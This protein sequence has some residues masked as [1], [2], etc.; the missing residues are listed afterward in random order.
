MR[1]LI[2]DKLPPAGVTA[3]A[4]LGV[5]VDARPELGADDLPEV[6]RATG[7][8]I[9]V[10]RS[11]KVTADAFA[12]APGLGLV[13][14]AGAGVNTIDVAAANRHAV[15]VANCPGKN[16]IAVAELTMGLVL[17]LDRRLPEAVND[18]Q[19]G[20]W[21]KKRYGNARGLHGRRMGLVGFG[22]IGRE[23]AMRARA[24]GLVVEAYDPMLTAAAAADNEVELAADLDAMLGRCDV[25]SVHVPY[26]KKTHHLIGARELALL[27]DG[28]IVVHTARG[29]VV[30]D[31]ALADAVKAGRI[32]AALDV[33]EDEPAGSEAQFLSSVR[34]LPGIYATP[35]IGAS[36]D[37]AESA[38]AAE[39]VRIID[40]YLRT[41]H[42]G[43]AVNLDRD[44]VANFT[45]VVRHR[46]RVGVLATVLGLVREEQL[47]VQQMQNVI[48]AAHE[49][50]CAT[51]S[52]ERAPSDELLE[53][54]RGHADVIAV[55]LRAV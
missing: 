3:I 21:N 55:A 34:E 47:N 53:R 14:R 49:T 20:M 52:L 33:F 31:A 8:E 40:E 10:V 30:D 36:T 15:F 39:A 19:R 4:A 7:A 25:V 41:G 35:H 45:V 51:I 38:T 24:F 29:G 26:G 18:M 54:L 9:L 28:A 13:V 27:K 22:H 23:V 1:V 11:T 37:Q 50:A 32:R 6:L 2:A 43:T 12:A 17:A 5:T 42:V 44:R 48:F 46:D 16:A